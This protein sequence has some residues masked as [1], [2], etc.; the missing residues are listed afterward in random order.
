MSCGG[1]R[2]GH[3]F[4]RAA[5]SI[6]GESVVIIDIVKNL[7]LYKE[8]NNLSMLMSETTRKDVILAFIKF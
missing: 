8:T 5:V 7:T 4:S 3:R 1:H 6:A 2:F